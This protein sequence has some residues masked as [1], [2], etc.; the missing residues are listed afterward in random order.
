MRHF[1]LIVPRPDLSTAAFEV[2]EIRFLAH[3][4]IRLWGLMGWCPL[5][6]EDQPAQLRLVGACDHASI[7][8]QIVQ[9]G[10]TE[11]VLQEPAG[12]RLEDRVLD[13]L[14]LCDLAASFESIDETRVE[15]T[16]RDPANPPDEI[17]IAEEL[18]MGGIL[19]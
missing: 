17:L 6:H 13:V 19:S 5:F 11:F 14:R 10:C 9:H 4:G 18:R 3:D 1:L 7:D 8:H 12:R 15:L 2:Q 16:V